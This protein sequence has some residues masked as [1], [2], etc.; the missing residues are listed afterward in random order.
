MLYLGSFC[1]SVSKMYPKVT[2]SS[3]DAVSAHKRFHSNTLLSGGRGNLYGHDKMAY[4][5]ATH[6]T[7]MKY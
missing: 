5:Y 2:E 3:L 7:S 1:E 6:S 4:D